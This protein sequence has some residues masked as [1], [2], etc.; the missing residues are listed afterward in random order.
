[1]KFNNLFKFK[2]NC[3]LLTLVGAI[4]LYGNPSGSVQVDKLPTT[5]PHPQ[6]RRSG[7]IRG[8]CSEEVSQNVITLIVPEDDYSLTKVPQTTQ[9]HPTFF[10]YV[11]QKSNLP[12]KFTLVE[13]GRTIYTKE[14][15]VPRSGLV[16]LTLPE[17]I[18]PLQPGK[19]YRWTASLLCSRQHPSRNPYTQ[20]WVER[21]SLPSIPKKKQ[22]SSCT[23]EEQA[24]I[25]YD[26][27]VC[28]LEN[29]LENK[30]FSLLE[31][32]NLDYLL[33]PNQFSL[34]NF[35]NSSFWLGSIED[36]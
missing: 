27:L 6:T 29:K 19:Q 20:A 35:L 7:G 26:T 28:Y 2:Q 23:P 36:H 17:N 1:M 3:L 33:Q 34:N 11:E 18:P 15:S 30:I 8:N 13:T 4:L 14:L 5:K 10:W 9:S 25:W 32:V 31:E 21:V 12:V 22:N 24:E 16:K